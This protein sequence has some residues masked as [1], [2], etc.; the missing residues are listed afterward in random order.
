MCKSVLSGPTNVVSTFPQVNLL[1]VQAPNKQGREA[2]IIIFIPTS[3]S[4]RVY[5]CWLCEVFIAAWP[6]LGFS[7]CRA[8]TR[9]CGLQELRVWAQLKNMGSVALVPGLW[10]AGSIVVTRRL[11]CS[12]A[13]RPS[14]I[15]DRTSVP[16]IGGW[17]LYH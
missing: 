1:C 7:C 13:C 15:R 16:C 12:T 8:R 9:V 6:F 3:K 14:W 10:S 5:Y 2:N 11:S 4:L 17:I